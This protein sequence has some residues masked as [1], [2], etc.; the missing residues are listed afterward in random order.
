[1]KIIFALTHHT[2]VRFAEV[3]FLLVV[4]AG[5]W[6]AAADIW[7]LWFG[8]TRGIVAGGALALAGA[9]LIVATRWGHF[10]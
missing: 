5:V 1:M 6:L 7:Q 3:G 2:G 4:F 10:R 9:L 8:R